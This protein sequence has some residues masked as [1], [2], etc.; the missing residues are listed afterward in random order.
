[1]L[2]KRAISFQQGLDR[3]V[4]IQSANHEANAE[5]LQL[6]TRRMVASMK[7]LTTSLLLLCLC[8][9]LLFAEVTRLEVKTRELLSGAD[10]AIEYEKIDGKAFY[11]LD[12]DAA[13]NQRIVDI[14]LAPRNAQ[15][16]VEFATD[17]EI[18]VPTTGVRSDALLYS[19]NNRGNNTLPPEISL[20]HPLSRK[21]YTYLAT[22]WINELAADDG[23]LRLEAPIVGN[24]GSPV[25]GLVRY[26]I[27]VNR[28]ENNVNI[29][30]ENHLAYAPSDRGMGE[31]TLTKR[32]N[33]LD[34]RE[35]IPRDKF[36]F[37]ITPV[38]NANQP[39]VQLV[40][41]GGL[42]PGVIYELMY[43]AKD[44]VLA[45]A[46]LAG[47]RDIVSLLRHGTHDT[48]LKEQLDSFNLPRFE[49][50]VAWGN[51]QSGRL[52]R[53][54]LYQ[55]F[56][57]DVSGQQV[58]DGI[59]PVIAGAGFGMFN[60]RF[61]MPTRT[62]G[63]HENLLYPN[64][65]FPFTYGESTDPYTGR[66]DAILRQSRMSN[67]EPK[68]MHIQTSNEYW[69]RGGSLAHTDPLGTHDA[70]IPDNV[71]FYTIGG[72]QHSSGNG[73]PNNNRGLG[74]LPNNHN[75]WSPIADSLLV[76]MVDWLSAGTL[77]PPSRYPKIA[78]N[79]LVPS[80]LDNGAINPQAWRALP[81][82]SHPKASYQVGYT[83]FGDEFL[84]QGIATRQVMFTTQWYKS[85]VPAV[86]RDN[87][88]LPSNTILPPL[89]A[90]PL[91][92]FV[93]WNLRRP[94]TGAETELARLAGGYIPFAP[95]IEIAQQ[96]ND[97]RPSLEKRYASAQEYLVEYERATDNLIE[98]GYLLRAFKA[99]FMEIA[100]ENLEV[101]Q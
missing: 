16:L 57:A 1:M 45:G 76:A 40:L 55:G 23:R 38:A 12:P 94:E 79:T 33:Q 98:Q 92:T 80:H 17:F 32:I 11:T 6:T 66:S 58:F 37:A 20:T 69:V 34:P 35:S 71:R 56:N 49:H 68:V 81:G 46:G 90:V 39:V 67:T 22:G 48:A 7:I 2:C 44:P 75:M 63:Q 10:G 13:A 5:P 28:P 73:T 53:Q 30:G 84:V 26:E 82:Y 21:G 89:T 41:D 47:I 3:G 62:N 87:N 97:P 42:E 31:A 99:R 60:T 88:D 54:F 78:N 43:E 15:G 24:E 50:T 9:Q 51:S 25:T 59:V 74:Q 95:N 85:L 91:G 8:P 14:A 18:L 83:D 29:A 64:D 93:P 72:S 52:L 77:P 100:Q 70:Q 36:S 96:N 27:I 4:L 65:Y 61:A 101:L 86:N 19:V